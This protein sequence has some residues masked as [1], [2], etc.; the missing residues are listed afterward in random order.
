MDNNCYA[1][2]NDSAFVVRDCIGICDKCHKSVSSIDYLHRVDQQKL[3][4]DCARETDHFAPPAVHSESAGILTI[5]NS[6]ECRIIDSNEL[7]L[8][9]AR[10]ALA[11]ALPMIDHEYNRVAYRKP[12]GPAAA[13]WQ[14]D[15]IAARDAVRKALGDNNE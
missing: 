1:C 11:L 2:T 6:P 4:G 9:Q 13:K 10:A 12:I 14:R 3:C 5:T 7:A 8:S 15:V